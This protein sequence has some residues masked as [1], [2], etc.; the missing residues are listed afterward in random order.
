MNGESIETLVT[1][2]RSVRLEKKFL[3]GTHRGSFPE[4]TLRKLEPNLKRFGITRVARITDL[5]RL[6]IE[7]FTVMRPNSR[8]LSVTQGKGSTALSAKLLGIM[9][10]IECWHAERPDIPLYCA[11]YAELREREGGEAVR[12][13]PDAVSET[14]PLIW[15][16]AIELNSG[17]KV[18]VPFDL[19]HANFLAPSAARRPGIFVSTNGLASG[20]NLAEALTH[21]VCEVIERHDTVAF[22]SSSVE[23]CRRRVLDL[24]PLEGLPVGALLRRCDDAGLKVK[25]WDT[26]SDVVVP[27]FIACIG[28]TTGQRTPPG[29]GAG[30]HPAREVALSRA[31]SEAAQ[32]RLTRISGARDDLAPKYYGGFEGARAR[33]LLDADGTGD[34]RGE[35]KPEDTPDIA[36]DCLVEDLWRVVEA[37]SSAGRDQVLALSLADDRRYSVVKVIVPGML[38]RIIHVWRPI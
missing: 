11:S 13:P 20:G 18:A 36:S 26:A 28:D 37:L 32:S 24:V 7:V 23:F 33:Y 2:G 22:G 4:D 34:S 14:E 12:R 10:A 16:T 35:R 27:C 25:F 5:D 31:V 38:A 1:Q 19:V 29:F 30:C 17:A 21:A 6:G 8:G 9:E 15:A 3:C